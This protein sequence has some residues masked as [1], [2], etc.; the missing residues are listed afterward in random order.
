VVEA[1][2]GAL[3]TCVG[4]SIATDGPAALRK[5]VHRGTVLFVIAQNDDA[6]SNGLA[7]LRQLARA[8]KSL[9]AVL[10]SGHVMCTTGNS[11]RNVLGM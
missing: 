3:A 10:Q 6:T 8:Y 5:R 7:L 1:L 11:I 9:F 4:I 2:R